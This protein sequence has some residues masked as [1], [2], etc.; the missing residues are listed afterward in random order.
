MLGD[1][2]KAH[3]VRHQ[4]RRVDTVHAQRPVQH[5][6]T[7]ADSLTYMH[8]ADDSLLLIRDIHT[9]AHNAQE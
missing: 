7:L 2:R 5:S 9:S 3:I 1:K 8:S 4:G 6:F